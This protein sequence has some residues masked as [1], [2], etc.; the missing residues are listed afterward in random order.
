MMFYF[1]SIVDKNILMSQT[2]V[3]QA[4]NRPSK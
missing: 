3:K 1:L 2:N 4:R